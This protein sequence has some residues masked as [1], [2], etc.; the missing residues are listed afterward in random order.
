[1][2]TL[3]VPSWAHQRATAYELTAGDPTRIDLTTEYKM[4]AAA[5]L[6]DLSPVLSGFAYTTA[7]HFEW[8]IQARR[9]SLLSTSMHQHVI[10]P[11]LQIFPEPK[12]LWTDVLK[13]QGLIR[14]DG[15]RMTYIVSNP[16]GPRPAS[17]D[18]APGDGLTK[19][20]LRRVK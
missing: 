2:L 16:G 13:T 3:T 6:V 8:D 9:A 18:T 4:Y 12:V 1:M 5:E 20:T 7:S 17:F 10:R 14:L 11:P 19:V 15:D